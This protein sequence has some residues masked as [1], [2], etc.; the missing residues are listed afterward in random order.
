MMTVNEVIQ[1]VVLLGDNRVVMADMPDNKYDCVVCDPPCGIAFMN[2]AFDSPQ[3]YDTADAST[4]DRTAFIAFM[5]EVFTQVYRI[6][7]PGAHGLVWALPRT[8][9][10]TMT[11]LEDCFFDVRDVITHHYAVGFP[12]GNNVSKAI[13]DLLGAEREVVGVSLSGPSSSGFE[14]E[15]RGSIKPAGERHKEFNI[16][17]PATDEAKR[18][19]GYNTALKPSVEFWILIRK[20]L[21]EKTVAANVLKWGVGALNIDAC[22]IACAGGSPSQNRREGKVPVGNYN[23][24]EVTSREGYNDQRDG[25]KIGRYPSNTV[26]SHVELTIMTL[27]DKLPSGIKQVI[28]EYYDGYSRVCNLQKRSRNNGIQNQVREEVLQYSVQTSGRAE[29]KNSES[30]SDNLHSVQNGIL[31]CDVEK[32]K[33]QEEILQ[34]GM[35]Q[36]SLQ[37][38]H[39]G[40]IATVR[41]EALAKNKRSNVECENRE[42]TETR[43]SSVMEGRTMR[44]RICSSNDRNTSGALEGNSKIDDENRSDIYIGTQADDGCKD[45]S[46]IDKERN[47]SSQ[48]RSEDRQR[49]RQFGSDGFS[50]SLQRTPQG[51]KENVCIDRRQR[52]IKLR[53][54]ALEVFACDI[55]TEWIKYFVFIGNIYACNYADADGTETI[56]SWECLLQCLCGYAWT[57]AKRVACPECGCRKCWWVCPVAE[58]NEQSEELH[59]G[60]SRQGYQEKWSREFIDRRTYGGWNNRATGMRY[61]DSGFASRFFYVAKPSRREREAGLEDFPEVIDEHGCIKPKNKHVTVKSVRLMDYLIRLVCPTGCTLIDPFLGSG[62]TLVAAALSG[63]Y[64]A[65][66]I[67]ENPDYHAIAVARVANAWERR[68]PDIALSET[69]DVTAAELL[70]PKSE[71]KSKQYPP[72]QEGFDF[73]G[74]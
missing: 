69:K 19:A 53:D 56:E 55:P 71:K 12:K 63:K 5:K 48:E 33:R 37:N 30:N 39:R 32:S 43:E 11:A 61:G 68:R 28:Q 7:K 36:S 66:G 72:E 50:E 45:E 60:G 73:D 42:S 27:D 15:D 10:W 62:T 24:W 74:D 57:A 58:L 41:Q 44:E 2:A 59:G 16:T 51:G 29:R 70:S 49:H 4:N 31:V 20:P 17:A 21:S 46:T 64:N 6:L 54:Y 47:S 67:E 18:Y 9:H 34:S 1:P 23:G 52:E 14:A 22:R 25:E 8:S 35:S 3:T 65:V 38:T 26:F 13:D 40:E